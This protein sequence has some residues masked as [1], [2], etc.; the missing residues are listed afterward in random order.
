[1]IT[2]GIIYMFKTMLSGFVILLPTVQ[3][4]PATIDTAIIY[5]SNFWNDWNDLFPIDTIII[6]IGWVITLEAGILLFHSLDWIYT[7]IRG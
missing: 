1:M 3:S 2:T 6:I 5:F 4:F 7:K